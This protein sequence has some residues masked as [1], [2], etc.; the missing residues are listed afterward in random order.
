MKPS[1][2]KIVGIT[3]AEKRKILSTVRRLGEHAGRK[4]E[5]ISAVQAH[6]R[7]VNLF[8]V[9]LAN[10]LA[11][12]GANVNPRKISRAAMWHDAFRQRFPAMVDFKTG[13]VR[14]SRL[15]GSKE[16]TAQ[17]YLEAGHQKAVR[18]FLKR[19]PI[20]ENREAAELLA[21]KEWMR[22]HN[23][24]ARKYV[25]LEQLIVDLGDAVVEGTKFVPIEERFASLQKRM[26]SYNSEEK[27]R[28]QE[29]F[30]LLKKMVNEEIEQK[31]GVSINAILDGLRKQKA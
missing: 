6:L 8:T 25:T 7:A 1:K 22:Y 14:A 21:S 15:Y 10:V 30:N 31:Y 16:R 27:L 11:K 5:S 28:Y 13:N 24:L 20:K 26:T 3:Q 19:S 2:R 18:E 29:A 17:D 4:R 12:K 23:P 9:T